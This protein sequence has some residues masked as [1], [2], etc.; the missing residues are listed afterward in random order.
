MT[1]IKDIWNSGLQ[2]RCHKWDHYFPIYERYFQKYKNQPITYLEIGVQRGGSLDMM[3]AYL[4]NDAKIIGIDRDPNCKAA[5]SKGHNVYIGDQSDKNFLLSI[6]KDF[7]S[8]DIIVDDGGH[9]AD[10]QIKSFNTLFH[11]LNYGGVYLVEDL[12]CSQ[13]WINYQHSELGINFLDYAKG[14]ADKLSLYHMREEW[15]VNRY[16]TPL[17]KRTGNQINYNNFAVNDIYSI[18]FYDSIIAIEKEKRVEPF[19]AEK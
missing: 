10:Q 7:P 14:L 8:F 12:H 9:T 6:T 16:G 1:T 13:Y 2:G 4:G 19:H 11:Y 15:F 5:E 18:S 3:R 17:D